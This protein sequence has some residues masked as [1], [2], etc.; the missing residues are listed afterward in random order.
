MNNLNSINFFTQ[1][2][3]HS[4][5]SKIFFT[6]LPRLIK[7]TGTDLNL[8]ISKSSIFDFKLVKLTFLGDLLTP[9]TYFKSGFVT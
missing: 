3:T 6:T 4:L 5:F 8:S 7:S 2:I 9:D 1:F